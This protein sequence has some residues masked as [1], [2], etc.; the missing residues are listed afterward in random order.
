MHKGTVSST[1]VKTEFGWHVIRLEDVRETP[2][3]AFDAVKDDI[4]TELRQKLVNDYVMGLR[5]EADI[6][7]GVHP[8]TPKAVSGTEAAPA[9]GTPESE[10][11]TP[12]AAGP[13]AESKEVPME[14]TNAESGDESKD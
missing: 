1:P 4:L 7:P 2:P 6:K 12:V 5:K 9:E 11:T 3:P 10:S 13:E 8:S 14:E